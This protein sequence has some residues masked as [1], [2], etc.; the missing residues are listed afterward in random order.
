MSHAADP[1]APLSPLPDRVTLE[2]PQGDIRS[3]HVV[4]TEYR[5]DLNGLV[6]LYTVAIDGSRLRAPA[7]EVESP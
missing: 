7:S 2:T 4:D 3:G 1:A 6:C 5:A